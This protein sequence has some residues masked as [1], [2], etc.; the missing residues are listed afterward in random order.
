MHVDC[1]CPEEAAATGAVAAVSRLCCLGSL[2]WPGHSRLWEVKHVPS[3]LLWRACV[4][5][6]FSTSL[7]C[8][9]AGSRTAIDV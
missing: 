2:V 3:G 1:I 7:A 4:G 5:T 6:W 8:Q 9:A